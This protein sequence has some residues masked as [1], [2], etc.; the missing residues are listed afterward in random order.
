MRVNPRDW[1]I[2]DLER[3]AKHFGIMIRKP[4][5]G[6]SHVTFSH[7]RWF[8]ILTVPAHRPVKPV[9]VKEFVSLIDVLERDDE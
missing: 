3:I 5:S 7:P 1:K 4:V 2:E 8:R 9:Y 6:S